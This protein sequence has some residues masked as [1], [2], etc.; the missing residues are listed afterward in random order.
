MP[1]IRFHNG[2]PGHSD[3]KLSWLGAAALSEISAEGLLSS[4]SNYFRGSDPTKWRTEVPH[5]QSVRYRE[6]W[7]GIDLVFHG[8]NRDL[9]WDFVVLPG[10]DPSRIGFTLEGA[11]ALELDESGRA[12]F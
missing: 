2:E 1:P 4:Y 11:G 7:P 12:A 3:V 10:G 5:Y 6:I 8:D 9:E